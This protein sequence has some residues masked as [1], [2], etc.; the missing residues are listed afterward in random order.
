MTNKQLIAERIQE[1]NEIDLMEEEL[2][3]RE[4]VEKIKNL[5]LFALNELFKS[6]SFIRKYESCKDLIISE[7]PEIAKQLDQLLEKIA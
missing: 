3:I 6:P 5:E 7:L 1:L 2:E 4:I